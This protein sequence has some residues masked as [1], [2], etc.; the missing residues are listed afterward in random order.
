MGN[1]VDQGTYRKFESSVDNVRPEQ[2]SVDPNAL[3]NT[4]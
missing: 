4:Q 3:L 2:A 1:L